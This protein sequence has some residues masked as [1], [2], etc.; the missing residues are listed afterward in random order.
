MKTLATDVYDYSFI[1]YKEFCMP[2]IVSLRHGGG[3]TK[4]LIDYGI[5]YLKEGF[6]CKIIPLEKSSGEFL[7]LVKCEQ[8][9]NNLKLSEELKIICSSGCQI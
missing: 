8:V 5:C 7:E 4:P 6:G 9:I 1:R 3:R 2:L